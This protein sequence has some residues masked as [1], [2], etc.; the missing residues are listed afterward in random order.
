MIR[1]RCIADR[2]TLGAL[3]AFSQRHPRRSQWLYKTQLQNLFMLVL[4][5]ALAVRVALYGLLLILQSCVNSCPRVG[6]SAVGRASHLAG[7][8][9][10]RLQGPYCMSEAWGDGEV[11]TR[12]AWYGLETKG[13]AVPMLT[14][15]P[16]VLREGSLQKKLGPYCKSQLRGAKDTTSS[17]PCFS[18]NEVKGV[19]LASH[20]ARPPGQP[21]GGA[22]LAGQPATAPPRSGRDF[23]GGTII[24]TRAELH[25]LY[26]IELNENGVRKISFCLGSP[27]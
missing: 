6:A 15:M 5:R 9:Q 20:P 21:Q 4:S 3:G 7:R 19:M 16:S 17:I 12:R 8:G 23:L 11:R 1:G 13:A 26:D 10:M 24:K 25:R 14:W 18:S 27:I 2:K 22:R